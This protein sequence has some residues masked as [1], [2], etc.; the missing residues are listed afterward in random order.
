M[1]FSYQD[2]HPPS[3]LAV[4][5]MNSQSSTENTNNLWLFDS[6]CN[7]HMTNVLANLNLS[8]NY[9]SEKIVNL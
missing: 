4:N 6:G 5:S 8:N 1:N 9:Y 2:R 7:I 3:Q